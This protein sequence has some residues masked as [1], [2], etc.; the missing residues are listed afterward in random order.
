MRFSHTR[1][2]HF[3]GGGEGLGRES[4]IFE[5][6]VS[7]LNWFL[8]DLHLQPNQLCQDEKQN[9]SL[10]IIYPLYYLTIENLV[11]F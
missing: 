3:C 7:S 10:E 1:I 9:F 11:C 4:Y 5:T 8:T 6:A 2:W